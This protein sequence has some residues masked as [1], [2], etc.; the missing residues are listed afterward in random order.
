MPRLPARY[1][2]NRYWNEY[3]AVTDRIE[4]DMIADRSIRFAD[5]TDAWKEYQRKLAAKRIV[6]TLSGYRYADE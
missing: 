5:V 6:A 2:S 3:L 1:W 4:R